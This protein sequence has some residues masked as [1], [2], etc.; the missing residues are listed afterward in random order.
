MVTIFVFDANHQYD[1]V[2]KLAPLFSQSEVKPKAIMIGSHTC[3]CAFRQL[4][5]I[6]S[7]LIG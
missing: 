1:G 4:H 6:T 5:E 2:K 7:V 3:S